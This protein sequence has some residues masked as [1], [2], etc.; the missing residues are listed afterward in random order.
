MNSAAGQAGLALGICALVGAACFALPNP[1]VLAALALLPLMLVAAFRSPFLLCLAFIL[2]SFFRLHEAVPQLSPLHIPQLLA[3][4]TLAVLAAQIVFRRVRLAWSPELR[5]FAI[6]F[7]IVTIGVVTATGRDLAFAYWS[8]TYVKIA[9]M[10][11]AIASLARR[12]TQF[13]WAS[14]AFV[15]AGM[16]VAVVALHNSAA[17]IGLV[18]GTR[19]T[20]GRDIGS[21]LGDPND[22]SLVLLFP[23]AF[24]GALVL[25]PRTPFV[26]RL[27]GLVGIATISAAIL[28]TQSRGGLLGMVAVAGVFAARRVRSRAVLFGGGALALMMLFAAAGI[29]GRSSGGAAEGGVIDESSEGRLHAWEAAFR[30]AV[31]H[32]LTG[33]G[34]NNYTANY[35]QYSDWWEGFAKAVHSTWFSVLAEGG[36]VAFFIFITMVVACVRSALRSV[37]LTAPAEAGAT[38]SPA[39]HGMAQALLAGLGGFVVSGTFLTQGFTWPIYI[40]LALAVAV[41]RY[42]T[43]SAITAHLLAASAAGADSAAGARPSLP[44]GRLRSG[45]QL[46]PPHTPSGAEI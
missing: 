6:L 1:A 38:Y 22:L 32:P 45:R 16:L 41:A 33:V 25:T 17:G 10:V 39:A 36:F 7:G 8:E 4:A 9:M 35:Y 31:A 2:F 40:Q 15:L 23:F 30:M 18:E 34:L 37:R 11:F 5:L 13:A 42:V 27:L 26:S 19:V 29:S 24:A 21:V 44:V 3:V 12:P 14:H 28:A 46:E 20:I 43:A